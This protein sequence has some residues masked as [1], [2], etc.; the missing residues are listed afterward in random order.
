M[1]GKGRLS[2]DIGAL[3]VVVLY[4]RTFGKYDLTFSLLNR[5]RD[6]LLTQLVTSQSGLGC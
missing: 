2:R 4:R 3:A 1:P 5:R 6:L